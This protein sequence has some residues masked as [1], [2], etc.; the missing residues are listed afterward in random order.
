MTRGLFGVRVSCGSFVVGLGAALT[1]LCV[2]TGLAAPGDKPAWKELPIPAGFEKK[3]VSKKTADARKVL[4]GTVPLA[5]NER[6]FDDYYKNYLPAAWTQTSPGSLSALAKEREQFLN[7]LANSKVPPQV[8]D[9]LVSITLAGMQQI[10]SDPELHPGARY[11]AALVLGA[12]N[13]KEPDRINRANPEPLPAALPVLLELFKNAEESD[14]VRLAA[15]LGIMRHLEWDPYRPQATRMAADT[16]TEI[17]AELAALAQATEPPPGRSLEGHTWLRRR[18]VEGLMYAALSGTTAEIH[19]VIEKLIS[20]DAEPVALRCTAADVMGRLE[21]QAPVIPA[22]EPNAKE[23]GHLALVAVDAELSRLENLEA[24]DEMRTKSQ[25][26]GIGTG[27]MM[28]G[29]MDAAMRGMGG[30]GG[31]MMGR[32][33]ADVTAK[34]KGMGKVPQY[35]GMGRGGG[36]GKVKTPKGKGK[37]RGA[38]M[39]KG[40]MQ[41][42]P[43]M[44]HM[45]PGVMAEGGT[46]PAAEPADAKAARLENARRRIRAWLYAV[47]MGLGDEKANPYNEVKRSGVGRNAKVTETF[48][49]GVRAFAQA[50]QEKTYVVSVIDKTRELIRV[51]ETPDLDF[52]S[53]VDDMRAAMSELEEITEPLVVAKDEATETPAKAS[54]GTATDVPDAKGA[55]PAGEEVPEAPAAPMTP[56]ETPA[57]GEVPAAPEKGKAEPPAGESPAPAEKGATKTP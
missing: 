27:G 1:A 46:A 22:P 21:Y 37:P 29:G 33:G 20:D 51:V 9:R 26:S 56:A 35:P 19:A 42:M 47:Q 41:G 17:V 45:D 49:R 14:G 4:F 36:G 23:L 32:G 44:D 24:M 43:G 52:E 48:T 15:L 57:D 34:M 54:E 10:L 8:H 13:A 50:D 16:K 18:A 6:A 25:G 31:P 28:G 5:G 30:A 40:M 38:D 11:N 7:E 53:F 2:S 3:E 39:M 12:L 55:A